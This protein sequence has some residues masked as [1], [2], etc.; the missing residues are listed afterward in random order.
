MHL[1]FYVVCQFHMCES[2]KIFFF[3]FLVWK[4][5]VLHSVPRWFC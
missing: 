5:I 3:F 4:I 2:N 1:E